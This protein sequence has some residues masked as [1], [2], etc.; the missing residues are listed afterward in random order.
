MKPKTLGKITRLVL[1][2]ELY[3]ELPHLV[4]GQGGYQSAFQRILDSVKMIDWKPVAHVTPKDLEN[5]REWAGRD[6]AGSWQ[7]WSR[8][9]LSEN[10]MPDGGR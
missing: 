4:S 10:A 3:E 2:K 9:A 6:D 1:T 8:A 5:V 7:D